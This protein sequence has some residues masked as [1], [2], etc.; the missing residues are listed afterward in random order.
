[1]IMTNL[2]IA[3]LDLSI[4]A[5]GIADINGVTSTVGGDAKLGDNRL[6]K[7]RTA[8]S[9]LAAGG[10]IDVAI[11]EDLPRGGMGGATTGMVQG[12]VR[13]LLT[14]LG[15]P[16]ILVSPATLKMYATGKGTATKSDMRMKLFQRFG[17]DIPDDNQA[18]A[19]WLRALG[20]DLYGQP[21][22]QINGSTD[23]PKSHRRALDKV[24]K[25]EPRVWA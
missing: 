16:Y 6:V 24:T 10:G 13:E 19:W 11:I 25:I 17:I 4:T 1:M 5:T 7:I 22:T 18:D 15:V 23:L 21:L 14:R 2:R 8:V 3:G 9:H 12:V 20:H